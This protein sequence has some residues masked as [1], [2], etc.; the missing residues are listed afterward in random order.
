VNERST[1]SS[2]STAPIHTRRACLGRRTDP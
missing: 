1:D 2:A